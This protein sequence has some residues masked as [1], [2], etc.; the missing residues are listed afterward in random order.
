MGI[1][2]E[3]DTAELSRAE[4][5]GL[6]ALL[7]SVSGI[8]L[9]PAQEISYDKTAVLASLGLDIPLR[10]PVTQVQDDDGGVSDYAEL[11]GKTLAEPDAATAFAAAETDSAGVAWNEALHSSSK[12]VKADGTWRARRGGP[13]E[14]AE[15]PPAPAAAPAPPA[16]APPVPSA[17]APPASTPTP[18]PMVPTPPPPSPP[19]VAGTARTTQATTFPALMKKINDGQNAGKLSVSETDTILTGMGLKALRDLVSP[20][21]SH[22]I[23]EM[24]DQVD[25]YVSSAS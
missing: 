12:A 13:A 16:A 9:T 23:P 11:A 18:A 8:P 21:N 24:S 3:I 25:A 5:Q 17:S 20:A 6:M 14:G 2:I 22:L 1:K 19:S 10:P 4:A 7:A 15:S